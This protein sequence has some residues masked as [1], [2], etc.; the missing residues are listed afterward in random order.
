MVPFGIALRDENSPAPSGTSKQPFV[1][2]RPEPGRPQVLVVDDLPIMRAAIRRLLEHAGMEVV[3][4]TG[5]ADETI[6]ALGVHTPD[7]V[8]I[9]L[10]VNRMD[11]IGVIRKVRQS[12]PTTSIVVHTGSARTDLLAKAVEAGAVGV[13]SRDGTPWELLR[14]IDRAYRTGTDGAAT[15][16]QPS[17][18]P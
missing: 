2:S 8:V 9:D 4:E 11:A 7:V 3:A 10:R 5:S 15:E 16:Q 17:R 13:P 6:E 18:T 12:H 1:S 14:A